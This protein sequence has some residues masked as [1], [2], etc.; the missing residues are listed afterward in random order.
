[1]VLPDA[2]LSE[3][4]RVHR[5]VARVDHAPRCEELLQR[6]GLAD[7]SDRQLVGWA[8]CSD[9]PSIVIAEGAS[10]RASR[11]ASSAKT[12]FDP[13]ERPV[14]LVLRDAERGREA[15]RVDVRLLA[16]ELLVPQRLAETA[17]TAGRFG[18]L[19]ADPK[20]LAA[21]FLDPLALQ[22][23]ELRQEVVAHRR[24]VFDQLLVDQHLQRLARDG[25][26]Q[27]VAPEGRAV[28]AGLVD[29][30]HRVVG[31]NRRDG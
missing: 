26:R 24:G 28:V 1:V 25:C 16:Q 18:Q 31:Q 15:D 3:K 8:R 13:C 10:L 7:P 22:A 11:Q 27:R 6:L 14:Q 17:G 23:F 2:G 12:C 9:T 4:P 5:H 30:H 19:E 21:H 29:Q 20:T